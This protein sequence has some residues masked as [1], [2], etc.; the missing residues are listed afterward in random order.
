M[1][2]SSFAKLAPPASE[3]IGSYYPVFL[4]PMVNSDERIIVAM[5]V[6]SSDRES[7]M[8]KPVLS[9]KLM[10]CM[11]S[12]SYEHFDYCIDWVIES[13]H[14]YLATGSDI[15]FWESPLDIMYLGTE[16]SSKYKDGLD[17][18][19]ETAVFSSCFFRSHKTSTSRPTSRTWVNRVSNSV[20][21]ERPD[22]KDFFD[23]KISFDKKVNRNFDF[24]SSRYSFKAVSV[25]SNQ[26]SWFDS[27]SKCILDF[28]LF[29]KYKNSKINIPEKKEIVLLYSVSKTRVEAS[30][31]KKYSQRIE[32]L[33]E[34]A[35]QESIDVVVFDNPDEQTNTMKEHIIAK[36]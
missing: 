24:A 4:K 17:D 22:L 10:K 25:I 21:S 36:A 33:E 30:D 2:I 3:K 29:E 1:N 35:K 8:V 15:K 26:K 13:L 5:V 20:T 23:K 11:F 12:K 31:I 32:E 27:A 18:L 19:M 14:S 6:Q 9:S 34:I 28:T 7:Y 16:K